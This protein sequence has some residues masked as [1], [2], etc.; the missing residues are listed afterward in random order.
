MLEPP[1][2]ANE[3]HIPENKVGSVLKTAISANIYT[4][5]LEFAI[6]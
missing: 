6:T 1:I 4:I 5:E 3:M 2:I